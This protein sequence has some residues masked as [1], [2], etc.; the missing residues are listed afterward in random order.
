MEIATR[1][2][3]SLEKAKKELSPTSPKEGDNVGE[4]EVQKKQTRGG[5]KLDVRACG[6]AGRPTSRA[7]KIKKITRDVASGKKITLEI[8]TR[9]KK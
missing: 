1:V 7:T 9:G 4:W 6:I 2:M 8:V 5:K 3:A